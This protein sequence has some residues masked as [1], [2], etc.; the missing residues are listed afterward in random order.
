MPKISVLIPMYNAG[1][2]IRE[3]LLSITRQTIDDYEIVVVDDGSTDSCVAIAHDTYP[4]VRIIHQKN[5]GITRA[6]NRGLEICQ[7]EFIARIDCYDLS[8]P[9]RLMLQ[10]NE[11]QRRPELGAV[12]GYI[13]LFNKNGSDLGVCKYP[14]LAED[15]E[16][17]ILSGN[18]PLPHSGAMIRKSTLIEAGGYDPFYNGREDFELW[19]RLSLMSQLS[20]INELVMRTLSTPSGISYDGGRLTPLINLALLERKERQIK[21][22]RWKNESLRLSFKIQ[23]QAPYQ[24]KT[25]GSHKKRLSAIF[26]TKRAAFLLRSGNRKV[27]LLEFIN[28]INSDVIYFRAW[29][30]LLAA[31]LLPTTIENWVVKSY[32][33]LKIIT[34]KRV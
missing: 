8:Y 21:G 25:T 19:T 28:A 33:R 15:I 3:T 23:I 31:I 1:D 17:D 20:N 5:S 7:G 10:L 34:S 6:L 26:F 16:L 32:K 29:I 30:G 2:G 11:L 12:G 14:I 22:V 9:N 27:A 4:Q 24:T 18:C 13:M